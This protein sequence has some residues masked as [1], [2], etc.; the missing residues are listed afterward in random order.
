MKIIA[1]ETFLANAG[2]RNYLFIRLRTDTGLAG[3]GEATLEW[4]EKTVETL[5]H[6][7]VKGRVLGCDPFDI[8]AVVGGM[9]RDQYQG[10]ATVMTAISGVEIALWDIVGKACNQPVYRLLGGRCQRCIPA[11]ANGWYGGA[12]DP[13][14]YAERAHEAV[15]RGY[16]AMKFDPFGV[17]WKDL[18]LGEM[19]QAEALVAAVRTAV[20]PNVGLMIEYHGRLSTG[21]AIEMINRL[22][23]F[24]PTWSEEPVEPDRLEL[25]A[26]VKRTTGA[27]IAAG[28]RLY[29]LT[30]FNRMIELRAAD[31]IQMDIA[32]CGGLLASKKIAALAAVQD[33][34]VAPHSSVGPVALA[35]A[36]HFDLSTPNFMI[37]EAFCEYDVPWRDALVRGWNPIRNGQFVVGDSPGLG[38]EIDEE[39]IAQHPY[40]PNSFP[41]LWDEQWLTNFS[42]N[43]QGV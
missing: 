20:G 16:A 26:V 39:I 5:C 29:S 30:D 6:E 1:F 22:E 28:E 18:S 40:V 42:Q 31:I 32:H 34:R 43:E 11:Y 2:L 12:R 4:Q 3:V 38:V 25:L 23:R 7:W 33:L 21:S 10:G 36:L 41:S 35:A 17:A 9:I 27:P 8:E 15:G 37:Q 24:H 14:E 13:H 19:E